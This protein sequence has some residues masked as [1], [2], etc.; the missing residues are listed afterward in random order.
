[1]TIAWP[2]VL[3]MFSFTLVSFVNAAWVGP[4]GTSHLAAVGL[5][6]VL[7]YAVHGFGIGVLSGLKVG[8]A[9][10]TGE[11]DI[12][13]TERL[14]WQ[15]LRLAVWMGI[16]ELA[17]VPLGEP[18]LRLLGASADSAPLAGDY[19]AARAYGAVP[20]FIMTA[21]TQYL[22]GRGRTVAPMIAMIIANVVN[23]V[24]D[25][26]LI[27]GLGPFPRLDIAG[28]GW[29][30]SIAFACG[31]LY[32]VFV[33]RKELLSVTRVFDKKLLAR[34]WELGL[35]LGARATLEVAS[36]LV[37]QIILAAQG[38][39]HLAAHVLVVQT[40]KW[41]FLPGYAVSEA[42]AV[43]VGQAVGARRLELVAEIQK[44]AAL[45]AGGFMTLCGVVFVLFP[46][47][48]ASVF[49]AAPDVVAIA[50]DVFLVAALFQVFDAFAMVGL[51]V[52]NGAGDTRFVFMAGVGFAW[53]VKLPIGWYLATE[54]GLGAVG[55]WWGLLAE[56]LAVWLIVRWRIKSG[57]WRRAADRAEALS[58]AG[59]F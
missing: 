44:A 42:V 28:A 2:I 17:F 27:R 6:T 24:L 18:L 46:G 13:R 10:A 32:L 5:G 53:I 57:G 12:A 21:L 37:F 29:A 47:P 54:G 19:F 3:S 52:L 9:Q 26:V 56:V 31:A 33:C 11:G 35:P 43:L 22:Q 39:A 34:I 30:A 58:L 8:V 40:I 15:G 16:A 7:L 4:L 45:I 41:S 38:D 23:L 1:M 55:A 50:T 48:L 20:A 25:P 49:G 36:Y 14:A 59:A 51:G